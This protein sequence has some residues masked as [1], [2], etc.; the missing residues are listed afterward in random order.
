MELD[1]YAGSGNTACDNTYKTVLKGATLE[2]GFAFMLQDT[3]NPIIVYAY[4]GFSGDAPCQTQE[5]AI[6]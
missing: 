6:Q 5:I 1:W 4:D 3:T 2:V